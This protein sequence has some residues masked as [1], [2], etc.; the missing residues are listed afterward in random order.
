MM[1]TTVQSG[2][3]FGQL[4]AAGRAREHHIGAGDVSLSWVV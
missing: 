1:I 4:V 3:A 2:V